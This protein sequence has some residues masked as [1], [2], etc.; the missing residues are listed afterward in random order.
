MMRP[1]VLPN[2]TGDGR[3]RGHAAHARRADRKTSP[4]VNST[5]SPNFAYL[6]HHEARLVALATQSAAPPT[7]SRGPLLKRSE[8]ARRLGVSGGGAHA[9][10]V[11]LA[12]ALF[13][14]AVDAIGA[15]DGGERRALH[16]ADG[17]RARRRTPTRRR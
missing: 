2:R 8:A 3:R 6:A 1:S 10:D 7:A 11:E 17:G 4:T 5:P 13:V 16:A 12:P 14:E 9:V 15:E